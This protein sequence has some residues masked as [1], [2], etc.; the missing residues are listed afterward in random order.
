MKPKKTQLWL[1]LSWNDERLQSLRLDTPRPIWLGEHGDLVAPETAI[2]APRVL[3][4]TCGDRAWL[5]PDGR[6]LAVGEATTR[7]FGD[8]VVHFQ[9]TLREARPLP[10]A[11][12]S[13]LGQLAAALALAIALVA[14]PLW[15]GGQQARRHLTKLP[16]EQEWAAVIP[17][18]AIVGDQVNPDQVP[19]DAEPAPNNR[20]IEYPP[21][22]I[23]VEAPH[24]EPPQPPVE[25]VVTQPKPPQ[26]SQGKTPDPQPRPRQS[27]TR[28]AQDDPQHALDA[29]DHLGT[30]TAAPPKLWGDPQP[31]D[32]EARNGTDVPHLTDLAARP[33]RP[34]LAE[35]P[36]LP[37]MQVHK[38]AT[39]GD[40]EL[41]PQRQ[42]VVVV[43]APRPTVEGNGLDALTVQTVIQ[44]MHGQLRHCLELGMLGSD[45]LNGRVRVAFVIAPDGSVL[46]ARVEESALHQA[47][48]EDCI[49]ER[50][51][52]WQFPAATTGLPTRVRHGFVFR[53]K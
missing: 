1:T 14:M 22:R 2:G 38:V 25:V 52:G 23:V 7:T 47:A 11:W 3:L 42:D 6:A 9:L 5:H 40:L 15:L 46:Q 39:D 53:T 12:P 44:R 45:K 21:E 43:K 36:L 18:P 33:R 32:T 51:R 26:P 30:P 13:E 48:T 41:N 50:I 4:L 35:N 8:F 37:Q 34:T 10:L 31:G 19:P 28:V 16:A 49:A 20:T 24:I 27:S 17:L 29:M